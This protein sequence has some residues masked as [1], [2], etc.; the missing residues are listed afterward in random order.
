[1]YLNDEKH[2][3]LYYRRAICPLTYTQCLH[4][5]IGLLADSSKAESSIDELGPNPLPSEI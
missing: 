1:M 2:P 4:Q 5:D 3:I